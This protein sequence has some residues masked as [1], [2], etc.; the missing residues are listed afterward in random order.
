MD[1]VSTLIRALAERD[2]I[3][4]R[5]EADIKRLVGNEA[6]PQNINA[7]LKLQNRYLRDRLL[8]LKEQV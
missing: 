4:D 5:L 6:E 8:A 2:R 1:E 3:I 7:A